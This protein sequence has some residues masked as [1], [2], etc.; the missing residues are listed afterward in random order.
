MKKILAVAAVCFLFVAVAAADSFTTYSSRA[1]FGG[2]DSLDWSSLGPEGTTV[3]SGTTATSVGGVGVT[4]SNGAG[5]QLFTEGSIWFGN[6]APGD[7]LL[8]NQ[9]TGP[10]T[11]TFSQ[12]IAGVGFNIQNDYL[13]SFLATF[14]LSTGDSFTMSGNGNSANDGSAPFWGIIDN[15]GANI[16][17]IVI[18][19]NNSQPVNAGAN[20]FA[21]NSLSLQTT[22]V[23]GVTPEPASLVL[24]GTGLLGLG[25]VLRRRL[26]K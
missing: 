12:G 20:D 24:F 25:G 4:V 26:R 16:T 13:G 5:F 19:T 6:F 8:W 9:A 18:A 15:T 21:I 22:A 2:N 10:D 1:S 23:A 17:S 11:L 3:A 7:N 14:T